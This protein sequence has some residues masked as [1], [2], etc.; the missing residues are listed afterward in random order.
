MKNGQLLQNRTTYMSICSGEEGGKV[1]IL[2]QIMKFLV[3]GSSQDVTTYT[4]I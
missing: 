3:W 2:F 4:D 1:T